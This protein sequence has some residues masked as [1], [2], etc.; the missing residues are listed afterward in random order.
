MARKRKREA[1]GLTA[2]ESTEASSA[3]DLSA[4][5]INQSEGGETDPRGPEQPELDSEQDQAL[6]LM[7]H[8]VDNIFLTGKAG[9]G[10]S[11]LIGIFER[12]TNKRIVKVAP[13]G[14]AAKHIGG[15]TIH[16]TFGFPYIELLELECE[17]TF[18]GLRYMTP[19]KK[20]VLMHADAIV[21]DEASMVRADQLDRIDKVLRALTG[22]DGPFGGK[23]MIIVGDLLQLPPVVV[24]DLKEYL[25]DRYGGSMFWRSNAFQNGAFRFIEL[26]QNHRQD[27]ADFYALL[28]R[29]REGVPSASDLLTLNSRCSDAGAWIGR[30][31]TL[32]PTKAAADALNVRMLQ[33]LSGPTHS[34][35]AE[36]IYSIPGSQKPN[37]EANFPIS[38]HLQL[39]IGALIMMVSNDPSKRWVNGTLGVIEELHTDH[40]RV[41]IDGRDYDIL[42]E[43]FR[44]QEPIYDRAQKRISYRDTLIVEQFPLILCYGMTIHKAQGSTFDQVVC[45][46][47]QCSQTGQAYVALSRCTSLDGVYLLSKVS[48]VVL[49]KVDYDALTF[50]EHCRLRSGV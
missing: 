43:Q 40:I 46:L 50:L 14:R 13:T 42:R 28:N 16:S 25:Y 1:K 8:T 17:L 10:K 3:A 9:T 29:I 39:K 34:Y 2:S 45:D 48:P 26:T 36:V 11:Y 15:A 27:D 4:D 5:V 7:E 6:R 30:T 32:F 38:E 19:E 33:S 49:A 35:D 22:I 21:I 41:S 31:I 12:L 37:L 23:Q 47:S 44:I 20:L 24:G 18:C